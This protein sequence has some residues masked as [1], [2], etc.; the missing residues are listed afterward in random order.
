M[1]TMSTKL[2]RDICVAVSGGIDSMAALAFLNKN[3]K[4]T[5]VHINHKEGNSDTAEL[6]VLDYCSTLQIPAITKK[7]VDVKPNNTSKEE[8][9]RNQ[10]YEFFHSLNGLVVTAHT[11]DDCVETWIWSSMHGEGKIIPASNRNVIRPFRLTNKS[12]FVAYA[13][14]NAV[15]FIEDESNSDLTLTRNYIRQV[16]MP[17]VL[18]VNPGISKTILKKVKN[19]V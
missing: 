9:W 5:V 12:D 6:L 17:H 3:H 2:P 1:I 11:L 7:I 8:F 18:Q 14:K 19:N 4:V 13:Q 10:R 15:P 16:M